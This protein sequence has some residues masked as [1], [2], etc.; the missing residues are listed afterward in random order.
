MSRGEQG[1]QGPPGRA[2]R[3]S[4]LSVCAPFV[5]LLAGMGAGM[6]APDF[7]W[8]RRGFPAWLSF[9]VVRLVCAVVARV[10]RERLWGVT[11]AGL[12]LNAALTLVLGWFLLHA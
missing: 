3:W 9:T 5:G 8:F 4:L 10:R 6:A 1:R 7:R 2:P 12:V 11:E